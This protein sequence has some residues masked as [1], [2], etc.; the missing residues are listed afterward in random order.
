MRDVN[1]ATN[2]YAVKQCL[3]IQSES[4]E[5]DQAI[6][7][8]KL[9]SM[10]SARQDCLAFCTKRQHT[11]LGNCKAS[12]IIADHALCERYSGQAKLI[13]HENPVLAF[14]LLLE[15]YY[16]GRQEAGSRHPSS[17]CHPE[18]HI[19]DTAVI[20]ANVVIEA[21]AVIESNVSV[22]PGSYIGEG[23]TIQ[24]GTVIHPNVTI[25]QD[26][27]IGKNCILH[28]G[29]V[30]GSDGFGYATEKG[31]WRKILHIGR[32]VLGDEVEIG[33]NTCIDRGMLD[34]TEVHC[35][36]KIDNL[37]HIAHN[38][39]VGKSGA[40]AGLSGIAGSTVIGKNFRM[41]G[42]SGIN[43][44]IALGD[45][46]IVGGG[47]MI[48]NSIKDSGFYIGI[49]PAQTHKNWARSALAIKDTGIKKTKD[50]AK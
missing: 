45:N 22:G 40:I 4:I 47:T 12:V 26:S 25:Y 50:S 18:S 19:D 43:G 38:V 13:A 8:Q 27:C 31:N 23:V 1:L 15:H 29:C 42:H 10:Q 6:K 3:G 2:L 34:D 46:I 14:T 33:A 16:G 39:V 17:Q 24:S 49:M 9:T 35:G 36:T 5:H 21:H 30:I 20:S 32:A 44:Q 7:I 28:S 48:T 11:S 37:V 41:G